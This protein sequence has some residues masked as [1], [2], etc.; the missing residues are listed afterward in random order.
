MEAVTVGRQGRP[1][2]TVVLHRPDRRNSRDR[3]ADR[4]LAHRAVIAEV[5]GHA[6][7]GGFELALWCDLRVFNRYWGIPLID[8]GTVRLTGPG[9]PRASARHRPSPA[10]HWLRATS[11]GLAIS[12]TVLAVN[13]VGDRLRDLDPELEV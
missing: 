1:V 12:V 13:T 2:T 4:N 3:W 9:R 8:G 7:A 10:V 6:V 11:P 5:A